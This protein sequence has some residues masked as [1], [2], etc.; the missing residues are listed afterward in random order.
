MKK[1]ILVVIMVLLFSICIPISAYAQ[2][3]DER[4]SYQAVLDELNAKYG[5][6]MR[7]AT[8]E[9]KALYINK[10]I[11]DCY[12][13]EYGVD[14]QSVEEILEYPEVEKN[15]PSFE[16][17]AADMRQTAKEISQR[18]AIEKNQTNVRDFY[19]R[20]NSIMA[21]DVTRTTTMNYGGE[22]YG[23]TMN[24]SVE[25]NSNGTLLWVGFNNADV[26]DCGPNKRYFAMYPE[27]Q[28]GCTWNFEDYRT[29]CHVAFGGDIMDLRNPGYPSLVESGVKLHAY[30]QSGQVN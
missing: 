19:Q 16:E 6:N 18:K 3:T 9:E 1:N 5:T 12:S 29:I 14:F 30:F 20:V 27:N 24:G 15:I 13:K 2:N 7:L 21:I 22:T 4:S 26:T 28:G 23:G 25:P 10:A 8:E 17:W 11:I